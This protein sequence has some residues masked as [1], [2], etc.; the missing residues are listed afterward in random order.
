MTT[1][2]IETTDE[3]QGL[4]SSSGMQRIMDC[5]ACLPL[6]VHLRSIGKLPRDI[7]TNYATHGIIVHSICEELALGREIIEGEPEQIEEAK[8]LWEAAQAAVVRLMG[9]SLDE[10]EVHVE[11]RFWHYDE[12][13]ERIASGRFDLIAVD[14]SAAPA[15]A[16]I[17]DYKT[18][19]NEVPLPAANWQLRHGAVLAAAN[20]DV[21]MVHAVIV[22]TMRRVEQA[23]FQGEEIVFF[24]ESIEEA[25]S[26]PANLASPFDVPFSAS[27]ENCRYCPSRLHCPRLL[28]DLE[29]ADSLVVTNDPYRMIA[30]ADTDTLG[31][32]LMRCETVE[33]IAK[34]AKEEMT[35]RLRGGDTSPHWHLEASAPRRK[36]TDARKVVNVII[37]AGASVDNALGAMSITL[38]AAEGLLK[39]VGY[40][41]KVAKEYLEQNCADAITLSNPEPSLKRR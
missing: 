27:E 22:Q 20:L 2:Q 30:S 31:R 37:A 12:A 34:A 36:V 6:T 35:E 33:T 21:E 18:G 40:K 19:H 8:E 41:G 14:R 16:V 7:E 25:L 9:K 29:V 28:H 13:G 38:G 24:M 32:F 1:H 23:T 11:E 5:A 39:G 10:L 17:L 26:M 3:R 15:V 4:P